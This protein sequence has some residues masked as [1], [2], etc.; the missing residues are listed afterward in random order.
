MLYRVFLTFTAVTGIPREYLEIT[1]EQHTVNNRGDLVFY[2][3]GFFLQDVARFQANE[4]SHFVVFKHEII[5]AVIGEY[6]DYG[7]LIPEY[8]DC[9]VKQQPGANDS[10]DSDPSDFDI[11]EQTTKTYKR[12]KSRRKK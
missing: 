1:A 6:K 10:A 8:A 12:N 5:P 3:R 4:W 7:G 9:V 11:S 2:D